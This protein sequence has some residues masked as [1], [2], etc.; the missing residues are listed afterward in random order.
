MYRITIVATAVLVG[1]VLDAAAGRIRQKPPDEVQRAS[2]ASEQARNDGDLRKGDII[3]TDRGFFQ[4][5]GLTVDGSYDFA[6]IPNPL[7]KEKHSLGPFGRR[8]Y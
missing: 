2:I 5:R 6:P 8:G 1:N 7:F 3:S 4:L